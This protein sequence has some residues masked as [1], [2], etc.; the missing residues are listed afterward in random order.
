MEA[1]LI[2]VPPN[3]QDIRMKFA[4]FDDMKFLTFQ[5][6]GN[7]TQSWPY[8]G[9]YSA[10]QQLYEPAIDISVIITAAFGTKNGNFNCKYGKEE[11]P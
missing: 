4:L 6:A 3:E 9:Q 11:R 10:G 5:Y 1:G 8:Q 2:P 7:D